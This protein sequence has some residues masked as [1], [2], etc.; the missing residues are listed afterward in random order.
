MG[1]NTTLA[2]WK[3]YS[4]PRE[5]VTQIS[6][7]LL[8]IPLIPGTTKTPKSTTT[9]NIFLAVWGW[10]GGMSGNKHEYGAQQIRHELLCILPPDTARSLWKTIGGQRAVSEAAPKIKCDILQS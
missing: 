10:C 4:N 2:A 1:H 3:T 9:E 5:N 8:R 6:Y 7:G